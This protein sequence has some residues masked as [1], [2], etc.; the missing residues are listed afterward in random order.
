MLLKG[1]HRSHVSGRKRGARFAARIKGKLVKQV[2]R[3][4]KELRTKSSTT[5]SPK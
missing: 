2:K 1:S 4:E 3:L 5:R